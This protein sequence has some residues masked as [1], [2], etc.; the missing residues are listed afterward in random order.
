MEG[1]Y[2]AYQELHDAYAE[3]IERDKEMYQAMTNE[4]LTVDELQERIDQVNES[5]TIVT[6][7]QEQFNT[8]TD[9]YNEAKASL[10]EAADLEQE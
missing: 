9:Q 10:Y 3:G 4:D 8:Y 6:E 2:N 5:Y 1:R 7:Q